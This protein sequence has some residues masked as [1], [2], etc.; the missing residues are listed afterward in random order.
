MDIDILKTLI[1]VLISTIIPLIINGCMLLI[2]N[3]MKNPKWKKELDKRFDE[4]KESLD[5][6]KEQWTEA[7]TSDMERNIIAINELKNM[8][9]E[10]KRRSLA[11]E[12]TLFY[13]DHRNDKTIRNFEWDWVCEAF[14][15]YQKVD[16]NGIIAKKFE[17]MQTWNRI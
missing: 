1:T 9:N 14:S 3:K 15:E 11:T 2:N 6:H 4:I 7:R 12:L 16:G 5:E 8:I 13:Q 10:E 17:E